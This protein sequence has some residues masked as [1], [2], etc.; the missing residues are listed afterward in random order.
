MAECQSEMRTPRSVC[1][2]FSSV[3]NLMCT[4]HAVHCTSLP[5]FVYCNSVEARP[6]DVTALS[7]ISFVSVL[8]FVRTIVHNYVY[9][10][11]DIYLLARKRTELRVCL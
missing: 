9:I 4:A 2:V 3:P 7:R 10:G 8:Y 5:C 6:I 11:I 1:F